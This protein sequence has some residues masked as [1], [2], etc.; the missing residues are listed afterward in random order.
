VICDN[1]FCFSVLLQRYRMGVGIALR[2]NQTGLAN[3]FE[4]ENKGKR[5]PGSANWKCADQHCS[6]LICLCAVSFC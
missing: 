3:E 5:A 4:G 1:T 6:A 2:S